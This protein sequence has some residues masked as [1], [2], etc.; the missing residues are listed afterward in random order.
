MR[1]IRLLVE[2]D[3]G[4]FSGWQAQENPASGGGRTVQGELERAIFAL[5]GERVRVRGAGRTDAGVHA[6]GQAAAFR[7]ASALPAERF[8]RAITARLPEGIAVL[9]S[10]EAPEGFDPRR[11]ARRKLYRYRILNRDAR[12]ALDRGR[13]AHAARPLDVPAMDRAA[14]ALAGR[15]DFAAFATKLEP[16]RTT[17][18]TIH[19]I[20]VRRE[21]DEVLVEVEGDGFLRGMVRGIVGTLLEVGK[22]RRPEGAVAE[23]LASR[24]RRRAGPNAPPEGLCL[25]RVEYEERRKDEG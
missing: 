25:V 3:G 21:G 7:T 8:A 23:I 15:H 13:V 18:R 5:T 1:T 22:G 6:L 9:A 19:G 14:R 20:A 24:D 17:V 10:A 12:A 11:D 4:P 2:Y 16:G